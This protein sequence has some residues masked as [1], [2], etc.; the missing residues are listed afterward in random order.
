MYK[1]T[2]IQLISIWI[3]GA[4][5]LF[6]SLIR[7]EYSDFFTVLSLLIPA[8]L[9]FYTIGWISSNKKDVEFR[10]FDIKKLFT[11]K[12]IRAGLLAFVLVISFGFIAEKV[13]DFVNTKSEKQNYIGSRNRY[14]KLLSNAEN[15]M[16]EKIGSLKPQYREHC[17]NKYDK[18]Y[19]TYKNC[20]EN[21][22]WSSHY[23]CI[24]WPGGNYEQ[25]NCSDEAVTLEIENESNRMCYQQ[26]SEEF[27]KIISYEEDVVDEYLDSQPKTKSE[28]SLEEIKDLYNLFPQEVFN[29]K[30]KERL[31]K[32]IESR[33]YKI[34]F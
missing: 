27:E 33:G 8:S 14:G 1:I 19:A 26:V 9:F 17:K 30:S 2:K 12:I 34:Q 22:P 28:F 18:A 13:S 25:F 16:K 15:C 21:M 32:Y 11:P 7:S 5:G 3:F 24:N 10:K 6:L 31:N 4:I 20:K 23:D 29:D